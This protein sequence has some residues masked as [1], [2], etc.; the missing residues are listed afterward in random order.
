M[1]GV[2]AS[3]LS[4]LLLA[5]AAAPA[6]AQESQESLKAKYE[7][8]I[9]EAW[10]KDGGWGADYDKAREQAKA[11]GKLIVAYFTRSYAP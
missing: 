10:F 6:R 8:K 1:R 7:A 5:A 11:G 2:L 3:L 4:G 9:G